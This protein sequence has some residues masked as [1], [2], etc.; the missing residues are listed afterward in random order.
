MKTV[1]SF[2]IL[3]FI[4]SKAADDCVHTLKGFVID[5]ESNQKFVGVSILVGNGQS[6]TTNENGYFEINNLCHTKVIIYYKFIGY[7]TLKKVYEIENNMIENITLHSDTCALE[8]IQITSQTINQTASQPESILNGKQLAQNSGLGLAETLKDVPGMAMLQSGPNIAK[9]MLHGMQGNRIV[10]INNGVRL[11][12]QQWGNDHAPEIDPFLSNKITVIKGA[13]GIRYGAESMAGTIIMAPR[14]LH[15]S[16]KLS[17]EINMIGSSNNRMGAV[18]AIVEGSPKFAPFLCL[19]LQTTLRKSG[20]VK[21]PNYYIPNTGFE[22]FNFSATLGFKKDKTEIELFY[23]QFNSEIAILKSAHIHSLSDMFAALKSNKPLVDDGFSFQIARPRQSV[24]HQT[25]LAKLYYSFSFGKLAISSNFQTNTRL[26]YDR[27]VP[28]GKNE[29]DPQL[30]FNLTTYT[31]EICFEH[32]PF[33]KFSG[34]SGI[35]FIHQ[36]NAWDFRYLIP[37]FIS[38][39]IGIFAIEKYSLGRTELEF[40]VRYDAKDFTAKRNRSGQFLDQNF[41]FNNLSATAGINYYISNKWQ[42]KFNIGNSFRAPAANELFIQGFHNATGF[43]E[44]G[45]V[46]LQPERGIKAIAQIKF[47]TENTKATIEPY[48]SSIKKYIYYLP[49]IQNPVSTS[50]RGP[51]F[52]VNYTQ[53]DANIY[54]ADA[55]I[56]Q[57]LTPTLWLD[58]RAS[59]IA[60]YNMQKNDF[61]PYMPPAK[62]HFQLNFSPRNGKINQKIKPDFS[63]AAIVVAKQNWTPTYIDTS[64]ILTNYKEPLQ[65][66]NGDF[67][68]TP[69]AYYLLQASAGAEIKIRNKS[70][71]VSLTCQN[72]TNNTYRDYMNRFRYF[73]DEMG[74]N[75]TLRIKSIL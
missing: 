25:L 13:G 14:D 74:R 37:N 50:F 1:F 45:N 67:A 30:F 44:K 70:F 58:T 23:S 61:L 19:R 26:E 71:F 54:G 15:Y 52:V 46:N 38:N 47:A 49:D 66:T 53:N 16:S 60:G 65:I 40:G 56:V 57:N 33:S 9:P 43:F 31:N 51:S 59:V 18:S 35:N 72:I 41:Q 20:N 36:G 10:L 12:S 6:A 62:V 32:K 24:S 29:I 17:A 64:I 68:P 5:G 75:F 73:A 39:Q 63:I 69:S 34:S 48:F 42:L 8:T 21:A 27:A 4:T 55:Q 7:K 28:R 2:F 3:F 11:E 22:E